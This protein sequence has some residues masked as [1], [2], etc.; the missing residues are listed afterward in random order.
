LPHS[1]SHVEGQLLATYCFAQNFRRRD[2]FD[3]IHWQ[4]FEWS[5]L[6]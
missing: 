3:P 6:T 4:V 2:P 5:S 1:T